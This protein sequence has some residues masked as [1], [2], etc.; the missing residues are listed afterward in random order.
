MN[1]FLASLPAILG[2]VGF[3][4]YLLV[5]K[6][7]TA[8]PIIQ[9]VLDKLQREAP[10]FYNHIQNLPEKEMIKLIKQDNDFRNEISVGDRAILSKALTNQF[11]TNIFVYSLCGLLLIIG[12]IL[13]LRPKPLEIQSITLQNTN[14]TS[15]EIITDLDPITVTWTS[16]GSNEQLYAVLVNAE[17]GNQTKR[18]AVQASEGR[19][20]FVVDKYSNFD[21]ILT[22]REPYGYNRIKAI[23]YGSSNSFQSK[24]VEIKVGIKI[25]AYEEKPNK[26]KFYAIIDQVIADNFLF[27]PRLA[28][29]TD[30]HF[31]G[32][33]IFE[34]PNYSSNPTLTIQD[35]QNYTSVNLAFTVNPQDIVDSKLIRTDIPSLKNAILALRRN[36]K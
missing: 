24:E 10:E 17:T 6:S 29:F 14:T 1:T 16:T 31:N 18:I 12:I 19:V 7:I 26:L 15:K 28:L 2:I 33:K 8:D 30:E 23:L 27:A 9:K 36:E 13:F 22:N 11:L 21:K 32:Q 25:I 4:T 20:K 34:A 3:V 5:K 35:P